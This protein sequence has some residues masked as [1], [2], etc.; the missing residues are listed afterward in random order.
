LSQETRATIAGRVTDPTRFGNFP[1]LQKTDPLLYQQLSTLGFF[2]SRTIAKNQLLR[3]FPHMT[4]LTIQGAPLG[5][6]KYNA[7]QLRFD[8]RFSHGWAFNTHY[9]WS[10]T[11]SKDWFPN[12][13]DPLP[14][15]RESDFSRPHRWVATSIWEFPFG[16]GRWL[17]ND[18]P[19][20]SSV[21]GGWQLGTIWQMQSGECIDFGNVFYYGTNLHDITLNR[22]ERNRD[23]WF[24]TSLF[25]R[26]STKTAASFHRRV[27]PNRL[28]WLRTASLYQLDVNI[29]RTVAIK[30]SFKALFRVDLLNAP[31]HQV[32][33]NPNVD[34]TSAS[35]GKI[36]DYVN[37]PRYIQFQ[38]RLVF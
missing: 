7:L 36:N 3:P 17:L 12:E 34:P 29:Q 38:L 35:F 26:D 13:F 25:E 1:E 2:T 22:G 24:N 19:I 23:R 15:W 28:N 30:E 6:N 4:G 27:F 9:E 31:N 32:L 16:K 37:T 20:A 33:G 5:E 14:D 18:T 10:H 8:K 11:M 21:L